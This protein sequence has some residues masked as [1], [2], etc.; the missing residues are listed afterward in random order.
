MHL[1]RTCIG[2]QREAGLPPGL[3]CKPCY[4]GIGSNQDLGEPV[5][6]DLSAGE[7]ATVDYAV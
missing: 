3:E 1:M 7:A 6:V 2:G 4:C 5:L